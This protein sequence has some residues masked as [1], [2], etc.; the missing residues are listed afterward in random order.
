ME[1]PG[2]FPGCG[3]IKCMFIFHMCIQ[4]L[5]SLLYFVMSVPS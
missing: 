3:K 5:Y 4:D 2:S 1:V